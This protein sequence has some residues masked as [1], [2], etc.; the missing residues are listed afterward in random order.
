MNALVL[1][2]GSRR[3][4]E[5]LQQ[6]LTLARSQQRQFAHPTLRLRDYPLEQYPVVLCEPLDRRCVKQLRRILDTPPQLTIHVGQ[7]QRQI[8]L[9]RAL[10][11]PHRASE[12]PTKPPAS[13]GQDAP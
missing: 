4:V 5:A 13:S 11:R 9:R 6:L 2:I 7:M 12:I 1:R 3:L 10:L 8:K